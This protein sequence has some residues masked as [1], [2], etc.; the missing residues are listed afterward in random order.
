MGGISVGEI[1]IILIVA[2]F[3][4]PYIFFI[5]TLRKAVNRC[6]VQN[7]EISPGSIWLLLIP[8]FHLIWQFYVVSKI[9]KSLASELKSKGIETPPNPTQRVGFA[10]CILTALSFL[11]QN[12]KAIC[13]NWKKSG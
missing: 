7:R 12:L 13:V 1:A 5:L 6:Q 2:L 11:T 4:L 10:M 8:V 3:L 9:S